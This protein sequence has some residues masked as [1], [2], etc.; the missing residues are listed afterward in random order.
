M[1][2]LKRLGCDVVVVAAHSGA[3]T[4]RR[5][6]TRC[7]TGERLDPGR[8]AGARH[9]RDPGRPCARR[10]P[11]AARDQRADRA[12]RSCSASRDYW[13]MRLAVMELDLVRHGSRWSLRSAHLADAELQR[14][15]RGPPGRRRGAQAQHDEGRHVRQLRRSG[16]RPRRC[17]PRGRP[18]RTSPII[19]FVNYVQADAVKQ[20]L[21]GADASLPVLSI[22]APFNRSA[23]F[24]AGRRCRSATSRGSTSTTTPCSG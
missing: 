8:P 14:R 19:D 10:H 24:P 18:S 16:P 9:R 4:S 15:G 20:G 12:G 11:A 3:D 21:T 1:P 22:A 5:T 6:A 2:K 7:P 13:G 23:S 17:R